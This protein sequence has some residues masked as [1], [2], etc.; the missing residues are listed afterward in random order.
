MAEQRQLFLPSLPT[1]ATIRR[2][3]PLIFPEGTDQRATATNELAAAAAFVMLYL[4]AVEGAERWIRPDQVTRMT[5]VQAAR[6][7][8]AARL[9]WEAE[10]MRKLGRGEQLSNRW[11]AHGTREGIRDDTIRNAWLP[12]RAVVKRQGLATTSARPTWALEREFAELLWWGVPPEGEP[13][14]LTEREGLTEYQ[15]KLADWQDRHLSRGA[16]SRVELLRR[17]TAPADAVTV[18]VPGSGPRHLSPGVSSRISK[19]VIEEFA[20]RFLIRPAVIWL[21]ESSNHAP[22]ADAD[23]ARAV[24]LNIGD[25]G[26]LPDIILVDLEPAKPLLIFCEVVATDG[27]MTEARK[28]A[29]LDL[30]SSGGHDLSNIVLMTAFIDREVSAYKKAS[31]ALASGTFAWAASEPDRLIIHHDAILYPAKLMDILA[32]QTSRRRASGTE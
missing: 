4:G 28:L 2:R 32:W 8:R 11:Y 27:P 5:D 31:S 7:D 29:I 12:A 14:N 6:T 23:M 10:S 18:N 16:R 3:L 13:E 22:L 21:S 25:S 9:A 30:A 17:L 26:I 1:I 15:A 20:P 19:A 24:G